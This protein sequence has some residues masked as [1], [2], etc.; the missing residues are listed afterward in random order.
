MNRIFGETTPTAYNNNKV[1]VYFVVG[2]CYF[3]IYLF[4]ENNS[5]Q[6]NNVNNFLIY[7]IRTKHI[8]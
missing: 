7:N 5:N 2:N 6:F 4:F 8:I 3:R 1:F